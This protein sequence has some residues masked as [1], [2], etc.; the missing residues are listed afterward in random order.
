MNV[1]SESTNEKIIY[2]CLKHSSSC[3]EYINSLLK[4]IQKE[5]KFGRLD[6]YNYE[7]QINLLTVIKLQIEH[8]QN[9]SKYSISRNGAIIDVKA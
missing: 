7:S 6:R 2:E 3:I 4:A 1:F 9:I 8:I 5:F